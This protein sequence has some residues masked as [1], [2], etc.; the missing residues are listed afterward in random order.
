LDDIKLL[1]MLSIIW[2]TKRQQ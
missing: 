2:N 1:A